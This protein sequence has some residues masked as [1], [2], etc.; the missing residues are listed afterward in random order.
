LSRG[1]HKVLKFVTYILKKP[2]VL[3]SVYC[4]Q[5]TPNTSGY[6][7]YLITGGGALKWRK[8]GEHIL[9]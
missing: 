1:G 6:T 5:H 7:Y 4:L 9:E 8:V 3:Y 2:A